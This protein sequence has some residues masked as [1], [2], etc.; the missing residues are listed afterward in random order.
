VWYVGGC[1]FLRF[2]S[3]DDPLEVFQ[4]HCLGGVWG[5]FATGFFDNNQGVLYHDSYRQGKFMGYQLVGITVIVAFTSI[6]SATAFLM[7][8]KLHMLR[9][10]PAVE[11]IGFD[12]AEMG[13]VS[14]KFL[15]AVNEDIKLKSS[16]PS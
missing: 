14:D 13:N 1:L 4:V 2:Y 16:Q 3:I 12:L 7:M 9:A 5:L 11:E 15:E 8:R 6:I 10:D